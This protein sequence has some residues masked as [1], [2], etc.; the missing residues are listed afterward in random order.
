[1]IRV[2]ASD[3][4]TRILWS[5]PEAA[6]ALPLAG[7]AEL[8]AQLKRVP[9]DRPLVLE[10]EGRWFSG[11][12]D[13]AEWRRYDVRERSAALATLNAVL[14]RV[15]RHPSLT[16]AVMNGAA[17]GGGLVL[18]LE[19]DWR[20]ALAPVMVLAPMA[21]MGVV[22]SPRFLAQLEAALGARSLMRLVLGQDRI[23]VVPDDPRQQLIHA[24][25]RQLPAG[26]RLAYD[27]RAHW[28]EDG[29]IRLQVDR[30]QMPHPEQN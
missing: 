20:V 12:F 6:N 15:R 19:T 29:T 14:D 18:A 11:G 25:T 21:A 13:Q 27:L 17:A 16:V 5:R 1:M 26:M 22:P 9:P 10:G 30:A 24:T 4:F 28:P 3:A 2:D 23:E 8:E 7:W